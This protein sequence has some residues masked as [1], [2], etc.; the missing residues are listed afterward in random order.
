ML[1]QHST[2]KHLGDKSAGADNA[3]R[4]GRA[5]FPQSKGTCAAVYTENR[6]M[7]RTSHG[8]VMNRTLQGFGIDFVQFRGRSVTVPNTPTNGA[9][10]TENYVGIKY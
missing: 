1:W 10:Y 7:W 2:N 3:R 5:A 8:A 6:I 9:D 4:R